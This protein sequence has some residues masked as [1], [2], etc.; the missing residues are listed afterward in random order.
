LPPTAISKNQQLAEAGIP[1][2]TANRYEE[3]AGPREQQAQQAADGGLEVGFAL[4]CG[5]HSF[6]GEFF[7]LILVASAKIAVF[8]PLLQLSIRSKIGFDRVTT[9]LT[10]NVP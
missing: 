7:G 6:V 3:L 4:K 2:R 5:W 9:T 1:H 10:G 8:Q